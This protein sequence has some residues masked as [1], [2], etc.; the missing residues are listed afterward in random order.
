MVTLQALF[1]SFY[2]A[3]YVIWGGQDLKL[4]PI[5]FG[6]TVAVGGV[7][8]LFGAGL[9]AWSIRRFGIGPACVVTSL[10]AA[11]GSFFIPLAWGGPVIGML[12]LMVSQVIGDS[13]GTVGEI[14]GRSIRQT[15]VKPEVLGRVGG[16]FAMLQG[17][18]GI[19]G[20]IIGG[21]LASA[22]IGHRE[23]MLVASL[24]MT[25]TAALMLAT[26]LMQLHQTVL[27]DA[28]EEAEERLDKP[29]EASV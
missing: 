12:M 22:V 19:V 6:S 28:P 14:A 25:V 10:I 15:L 3:M 2:S 20:S 17:V 21:V 27:P 23:T 11:A 4:T 18:T 7:A 5:M 1:G 9:A 16:A 24:G 8:S 13:F 29:G 26:P